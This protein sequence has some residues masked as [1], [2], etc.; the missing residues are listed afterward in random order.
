MWRGPC[1]QFFQRTDKH[2]QTYGNISP[3]FNDKKNKTTNE[4]RQG[5]TTRHLRMILYISLGFTIMGMALVAL[6]SDII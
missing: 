1:T 2:M 6:F 4:A 3:E 5:Y